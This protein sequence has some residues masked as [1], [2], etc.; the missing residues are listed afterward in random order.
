MGD[1]MS[2]IYR[3]IL[4]ENP[5]FQLT[6]E[7]QREYGLHKIIADILSSK[8]NAQEVKNFLNPDLKDLYS[9]YL[10]RGIKEAKELIQQHIALKDLITIY[11]D[12]DVDGITAT[13]VLYLTLKN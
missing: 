10:L 5:N 4:K 13:S 8:L 2:K 3:W 9:P 6:Q 11:G 7:I 1:L 12:Y